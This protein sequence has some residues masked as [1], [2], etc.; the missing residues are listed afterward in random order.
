LPSLSVESYDAIVAQDVLEHLEDPIKLAGE[1]A[2]S[3]RIGGKVIFANCFS[4]ILQCH[5][6]S[7]FHLRYTFP[8]VMKALGLRFVGI[9]NGASHAQ[10]YERVGALNLLKARKA[11]AASKIIG[12]LLNLGHKFLMSARLYIKRILIW[13]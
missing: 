11:E 8:S 5:L 6:P 2:S 7:N 10:I 12:P 1:I 13:K 9:V 4:P 3:I